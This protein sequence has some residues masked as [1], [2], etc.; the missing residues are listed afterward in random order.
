MIYQIMIQIYFRIKPSD[1]CHHIFG[2]VKKVKLNNR[3]KYNKIQKK[4]EQKKV[5]KIRKVQ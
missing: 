2:G 3:S 4:V 1:H 5:K